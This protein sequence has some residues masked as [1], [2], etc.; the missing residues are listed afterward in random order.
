MS[1]PTLSDIDLKNKIAWVW[2]TLNRHIWILVKMNLDSPKSFQAN[3]S[4]QKTMVKV[5]LGRPISV[6][7]T[8]IRVYLGSF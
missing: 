4:V 1:D 8:M 3:H 5:I 6:I 2:T 7:L